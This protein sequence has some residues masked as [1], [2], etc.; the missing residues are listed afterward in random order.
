MKTP[1]SMMEDIAAQIIEST[2]LLEVIYKQSDENHETDCAISCLIRSL[3]QTIDKANGY[4]TELDGLHTSNFKT[5]NNSSDD[6]SNDIFDAVISVGKAK[7]VAH[8]LSEGCFTDKDSNKPECILSAVV[9]DYINETQ[10][11]LKIIESK[12]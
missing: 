6:I 4:V 9:F 10:R 5:R 8:Q 1:I 7:E 12:I 3:R 2:S 11:T